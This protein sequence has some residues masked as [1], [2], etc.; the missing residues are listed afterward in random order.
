MKPLLGFIIFFFSSGLNAQILSLPEIQLSDF[1][2]KQ[3]SLD[4]SAHAIVLYEIGRSSIEKSEQDHSLMVFHHYRAQI[5]ILSVD[6]YSQ[7]NFTLPMYKF[8]STFETVYDIRGKTYNVENGKVEFTELKRNS[9]IVE[10]RSEFLKLTKFTLPDIKVGSIIDIEY[11][12]ISPDIFNFRS[13]QFQSDI[14]KLKSEY[15]VLIPAIYKYNVT[16]KGPLK[17]KDTKS[18]VNKEC[19]LLNG[20]KIDCSDLTYSMH[21]IASFVEESYM[22]APKNYISAINFELEE[23]TLLNGG[24]KTFTKNWTDVDR[25][26]MAEKSF[27]GQLKRTKFLDEK[28]PDAIRKITDKRTRAQKVYDFIQNNIRWNNIY[29]KY[30]QNGIEDSFE[31]RSGNVGDINLALISALN[32][33]DIEAYPVIVSTRENG[34]PNQLHPVITDF[35]YVIAGIKINDETI[36]ADATEKFLPFGDIPLRCVNDKGRIIYSRK[37]SEW[38][39]LI[40]PS[41]SSIDYAFT[42]NL[43]LNGTLIGKLIIS[44][45]GQDALRKR[46]EIANYPTIEEYTEKLDQRLNHIKIANLEVSHLHDANI[47]LV[48]EVDVEIQMSNEIKNG[49]FNIN[50]IF[51]DRTTR[52]PFNLDERNYHVDLGSRRNETHSINIK[53]PEGTSLINSPKNLNIRFPDDAVKYKFLS[54]FEDHVFSTR[55]ELNLQKA[56]YDSDE[57]FGLKDVFSRMIQHQKIDFTFQYMP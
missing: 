15:R 14:P 9:I 10:N 8:G 18:K 26:L 12:V 49:T 30:S 42:G 45:N 56:I 43:D 52:N 25:E 41:I 23:M 46:K 55:Q 39:P 32:A 48:E 13:W 28:I 33:V 53:M 54:Q 31:K 4:T 20:A 19:L 44:Y 2:Q 38:I 47:L 21:D 57:Y 37:S 3:Y 16:L 7:A 29:G 1:Q 22:L 50:P 34:I 6:G 40:N 27:G 36:L 35:N 11:T 17:L 24:K 5:K 51:I